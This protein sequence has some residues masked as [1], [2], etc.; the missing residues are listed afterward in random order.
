MDIV[1]GLQWGDEG[2]GKFIDLISRNYDIVARFNG[3]ANAGHS[4]ERN[5]KRITLKTLPSGIFIEGVDNVIGA[6]IVL[7]P[8][9][10]KQEVLKLNAFDMNIQVEKRLTVSRKA[11]LVLPTH[12]L[13]DVFMEENSSYN[14]IGTTKN[15]IGQAYANKIL[16]QNLRVGDIDRSDFNE[17][18][19]HIV[20]RDYQQ[21]LDYGQILPP[22]TDLKDTFFDAIE[23]L[24]KFRW[25][26]AEVFLNESIKSGR[27]ILAEGAQAT[28]LDIDHGTYPY[29]TSST[30]IASGACSG[31]GVS[32]KKVGEIYG[33]TKAYCTRVGNGAFLTELFGETGE[34]IRQTGNEFGSNTGRPRRV[35]WL[36]LPAL[37]Y[38]V[39]INGVTQ[40]IITKADVLN[41]FESVAIC[42]HYKVKDQTVV[43][44]LM[45]D[46][47]ARPVF[48]RMKGWKTEFS[49]CKDPSSLPE[50]LLEFIQFLENE[51]E[52]PVSYLSTGPGREDMIKMTS[53]L[54][55]QI[56]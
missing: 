54:I 2:K 23:F 25:I 14:T 41:G 43:S 37:K 45:T 44:G 19:N 39:M 47:E 11:H 29:V 35:G 18:V 49:E 36:D 46:D 16:R 20:E 50:E 17:T 26:E 33:V 56:V 8:V 21:L 38:A 15:G 34:K 10:F 53:K 40:L 5:G 42:T 6:G 7:D 4:I 27:K 52:I 51:L 12:T 48:R 55:S 28:L 1:L 3:G 13:M 24:K 30:T 22:I 32:P 9:N 31:L